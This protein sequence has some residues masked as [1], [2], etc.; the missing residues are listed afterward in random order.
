MLAKPLP[1]REALTLIVVAILL[2]SKGRLYST[3]PIH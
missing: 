1:L 2:P 3:E